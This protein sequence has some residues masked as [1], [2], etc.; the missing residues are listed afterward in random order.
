MSL[1]LIQ[2]AQ[3]LYYDSLLAKDIHLSIY[4]REAVLQLLVLGVFFVHL[5]HLKLEI[6]NLVPQRS[7]LFASGLQILLW[8]FLGFRFFNL[9]FYPVEL[10]GQTRLLLCGIFQGFGSEV[11]ESLT[12]RRCRIVKTII[13]ADVLCLNSVHYPASILKILVIFDAH[14]VVD[15]PTGPNLLGFALGIGRHSFLI[16]WDLHH[17]ISELVILW[18]L[19]VPQFLQT[20]LSYF[21]RV[22]FLGGHRVG[23]LILELVL[24]VNILWS[25]CVLLRLVKV[26]EHHL[27]VWVDVIQRIHEVGALAGVGKIGVVEVLSGVCGDGANISDVHELELCLVVRSAVVEMGRSPGSEAVRR[28]PGIGLVVLRTQMSHV[29]FD[30]VDLKIGVWTSWLC[31]WLW[32]GSIWG[33]LVF[34]DLFDALLLMLLIYSSLTRQLRIQLLQP[35]LLSQG[36]SVLAHTRNSC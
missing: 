28:I 22:Q 9:H 20:L 5:R 35:L 21:I 23:S 33:E 18:L 27:R 26:G 3:G 1:S 32:S 10:W 7:Q 15:L 4:L 24:V 30:L 8:D 36:G 6:L 17:L 25:L 34:Q 14:G 11:F 19:G 29:L 31:P 13:C 2:H 12:D 16:A